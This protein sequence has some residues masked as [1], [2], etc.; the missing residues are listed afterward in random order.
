MGSRGSII[1]FLLSLPPNGHFPLTDPEMT[2]FMITL[3][4]GVNLVW[5]AFKDMEGGEIYIK[6]IPSMKL[7]DIAKSVSENFITK[8]I[9]LRPGEKVHE[10]MI[11]SDD[12]PYTYEYKDYFKILPAINEWSKDPLRIGKGKKVASNFIYASNLNN[13]WM[14]INELKNWINTNR[15]KIGNI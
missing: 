7:I 12:A 11:G 13:K 2:R 3:E 4:E 1:P 14:E 10:Q 6:K 5:E 8:I 15:K 9:G